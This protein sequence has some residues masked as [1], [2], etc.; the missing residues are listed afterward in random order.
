MTFAEQLTAFLTTPASRM[1]LVTLRAI[2]RDRYVRRRLTCKG[3]QGVIFE[4]LC[5][6]LKATNP[7]LLS[8]IDSIATTTSM[9][10]DAV[11]MVPMHISLTRQPITLPL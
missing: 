5:E 3:E 6:H 9:H 2:W 4:R 11:L 1:K 7:A 8:F 10:L